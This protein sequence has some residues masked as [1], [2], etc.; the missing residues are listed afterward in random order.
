MKKILKVGL[1]D[2]TI[3]IFI[4][5]SSS[6]TGAG[7]TGLVFNT[8][9]LVCYYRRGATGSATALTLAT[10]T[11]GGAHS[12]GGFVAIDG[13]NMPGM[14]RLDLSDAIVASGVTT[15]SMM[16]KGATNMAP[17]TIELQLVS[18]DLDD[19]VR[20]GLTALPNAVAAAAGGLFTRGTGAG[21]I[22][23]DAN[24]RIDVNVRAWL[25]TAA[26]TPTVAGV[27]EVDVTHWIGTAAAAPTV[28]GVPE[29]DVTH[30]L[31]TAAATPTVAG[32]PEVDVTHFG[33]SAGTFAS[34]R[35]EVNTSHVGGTAQTAGD[36]MADTNDIQARLPAALVGG[37]MDSSVG[38]MAANVMTAAAAAADF[39]TE[40]RS[41]AS[42]TA[43]S[44]TTTTMVDAARTEADTD[45]WDENHI[46][47]FTSGTLLGQARVIIGF[48]PATDT[49]T[50]SPAVTQAVG[51]H[52]YEIW[53]VAAALRPTVHGRTLDVSVGGEAGLDW[54][55]IGGPTTV[56]GLS[57]TTIKT[58]TD[59]ETDTAEI[60][61]A[62]AGLTALATQASV[63]TIDDFLDTEIAT[64]ITQTGAAAIRAALGL[65]SANLDTQLDALPTTAE[66]LTQVN[67]ALD[68]AIAELGVAAPTPTPTLRTGLMLLYMA[69]R[70]KTTSTATQ[71]T[72]SNNA[73]TTIAAAAQSDDTVTYEKG[74]FA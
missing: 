12:D 37:R 30:W 43:D 23:Q 70:N 32:V 55:N 57:G 25:D 2:Q 17:L 16:L 26:A 11:V 41:L 38:A 4:Q 50:F 61:V 8:A 13:T 67:A 58:A 51:T 21:Q 15:V 14:Y 40:I 36:I 39:S 45:Y 65:A 5:D 54:A 62:G 74:E 73:G 10:Q 3:D 28:A 72:I 63:N 33:G 71:T 49:I 18:V 52:T 53:P 66:V 22:N 27:P 44:G 56:Q 47:V 48:D 24:G 20:F 68:T 1:T 9:S 29:V 42:G 59:V 7:L 19:T 60:G 31:G 6:T 64:L 69:L 46:I 34:G 35:P